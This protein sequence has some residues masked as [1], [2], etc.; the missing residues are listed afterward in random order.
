MQ[1]SNLSS[2]RVSDYVKVPFKVQLTFKLG[3]IK[4]EE[5]VKT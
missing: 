4:N 5:R 1:K 3:V 2:M